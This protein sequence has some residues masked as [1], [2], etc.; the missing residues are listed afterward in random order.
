MASGSCS[1]DDADE[2]FARGDI[3]AVYITLP[4]SCRSASV[5]R[6]RQQIRRPGIQPPPLVG[7]VDPA[8]I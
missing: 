3:D 7:G 5:A 4:D 1:Y 8:T 6:L 2:R